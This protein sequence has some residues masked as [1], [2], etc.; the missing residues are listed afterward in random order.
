MNTEELRLRQ[1]EFEA[2]RSSLNK[3][4]SEMEKLRLDFTNRF[5]LENLKYLALDD[6]VV[7]KGYQE[8]FCCLLEN[9]LKD[10]GDMH[11]ATSFKFG[12][13]YGKTKTDKIK[14]YRFTKKFGDTTESAF[15]NV[16]NSIMQLIDDGAI[17]NIKSI[18]R[19]PL[20]TMFKGKILSTYFPNKYLGIFSDSHLNY[21]LNK[22]G[23]NYQINENEISKRERLLSFKNQDA[24]M[25]IWNNYDYFRFLYRKIGRPLKRTSSTPKELNDFMEIDFPKI[26]DVNYRFI[27][28]S[29]NDVPYN[30]GQDISKPKK[31]DF[32]KENKRN[33]MIGA[34][35][36]EIV[37]KAEKNYLTELGL[38][39]LASKVTQSSRK[40][41][42]LG[43]DIQSFDRNGEQKFI[44]VKS[45]KKNS[46]NGLVDFFMS[47]NELRH[48]KQIKN[49]YIY[50]VF[51]V[52]KKQPD[53]LRLKGLFSIK[54]NKVK[55]KPKNYKIS[56][57][58]SS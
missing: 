45:T 32:D 58:L 7:G 31:I 46:S 2:E 47:A 3:E 40:Y 25:K 15:Q 21:F 54:D 57:N 44:E 22:L 4:Y 20:S 35:G 29:L 51:S 55:I 52:H 17:S 37:M 8:S 34:R 9:R 28:K 19:N 50:I 10:T 49:Y 26:E 11:G 53:I 18:K 6:Y 5:S 14:K 42:N 30:Q 23:I 41:D 48:A 39:H 1:A 38:G 43:Y 33:S 16:K 24:V 12:I 56:I 13:Y 27:E 36:E